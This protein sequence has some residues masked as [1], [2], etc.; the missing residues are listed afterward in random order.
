VNDELPARPAG[1]PVSHQCFVC[2]RD[3][4]FGLRLRF[5]HRDGR[6]ST[7]C[8]L[9]GHYNG[10]TDRAHGGVVAAL[11]D[12]AMGWA[13]AL[14][15]R[16]FTYT[17]ELAVRYRSPVPLGAALWVEGWVDRH[18][19]RL[20]FAEGR[21]SADE[22]G[23]RVVLAT[24]TAKFMPLTSEESRHIAR[25]LLYDPGDLRLLEDWVEDW[26]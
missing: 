23:A 2:G 7:T 10:F 15:N 21:L 24:A 3:N 17:V 11:L 6:V 4:P 1:L 12:E 26:E 8:R 16:R 20:S 14:A 25:S 22:N 18:T 13:T 9:D 19:R 5:E